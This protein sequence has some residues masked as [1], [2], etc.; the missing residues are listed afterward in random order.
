MNK[1]DFFGLM[2]CNAVTLVLLLEH[3][4][5]LEL[6]LPFMCVWTIISLIVHICILKDYIFTVTIE[7]E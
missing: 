2:F 5:G 1:K 7:E 3:L 6:A 4:C